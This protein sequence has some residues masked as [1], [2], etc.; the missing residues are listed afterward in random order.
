[1][2]FGRSDA[3]HIRQPDPIWLQAQHDPMPAMLSESVDIAPSLRVYS[4]GNSTRPS[5]FDDDERRRLARRIQL[6]AVERSRFLG[7]SSPGMRPDFHIGTRDLVRAKLS[8]RSAAW[9]VQGLLAGR[10]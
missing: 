9:M 4:I 1:W 2:N 7:C 3:S 10:S 6:C 8:V 5:A